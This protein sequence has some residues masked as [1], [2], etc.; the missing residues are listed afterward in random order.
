MTAYP[1][2]TEYRY[3]GGGESV[4]AFLGKKGN[5]A[6]MFF[7]NGSLHSRTPFM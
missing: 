7:G 1:A 6:R 3:T 5:G 4:Y 2:N